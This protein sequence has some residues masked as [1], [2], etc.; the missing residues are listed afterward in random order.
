MQYTDAG[1]V[2]CGAGAV[3]CG[4]VGGP[5]L[6]ALPVGRAPPLGLA[7]LAGGGVACSAPGACAG[8]ALRL[9]SAAGGPY[10][11]ASAV[12]SRRAQLV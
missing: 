12:T 11:T 9:G 2:G 8:R 4:G 10:P 1:A 5:G 3:G 7:G 6:L